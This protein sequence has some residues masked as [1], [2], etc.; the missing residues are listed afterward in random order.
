M[1]SPAR[2]Q[3]RPPRGD[4]RCF[5]P[6]NEVDFWLRVDRL[7]SPSETPTYRTGFERCVEPGDADE[8]R[9]IHLISQ[10]EG[11]LWMPPLAT[12]EVDRDAVAL[13]RR[14]V[15]NIPE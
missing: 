2:A 9:L 7:A 3:D 10:R 8:S 12:E 4:A 14:W 5:D 13:P 15:E 1:R 11:A 6:E